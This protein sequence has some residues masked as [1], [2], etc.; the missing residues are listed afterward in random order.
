MSV[1][2]AIVQRFWLDGYGVQVASINHFR[3]W[4]RCAFFRV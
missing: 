3:L 2:V 1:A 4:R